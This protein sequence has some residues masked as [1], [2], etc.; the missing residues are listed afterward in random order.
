MTSPTPGHAPTLLLVDDE[1]VFRERLARAFRERGFE[2]ST[3]G[4]YDEALG[5]AT[6][7][8]PELAVVD[9]R[10]PGRG[11]LELVRALHALDAS[12]R[13][14]VLTGYGSIATA[15]EAVKLGAF[16]YLPKPADVD[17]LLLA[18]SRGP[19]EAAQVTEDF[20]PP[21]LARAEWEHIQRVLTDCGG[22]ISEAAR[23]LGLHRRSLQR[24]LQKYPPAQ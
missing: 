11:G 16:N 9:L 3:A 19:G 13:I 2:V 12:T 4:S 7:E 10:M 18:F 14:I 6:K 15:V 24:K 1:A 21:T 5:L 20:Q 23:R 22:N 17:D 8:S